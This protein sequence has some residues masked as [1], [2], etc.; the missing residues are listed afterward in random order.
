MSRHK[1]VKNLD[2]DEELDDFD[3]GTESDYGEEVG[4]EDKGIYLTFLDCP[5]D[6]H[7]NA[8]LLTIKMRFQSIYVKAPLTYGMSSVR[9]Y[10]SP[11]KRSRI[12]YGTTTTTLKR[13]LIT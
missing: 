11:T 5:T 6:V 9:K 2:L 7:L 3:G 8:S 10:P 12:L 4:L 1:L 13:L